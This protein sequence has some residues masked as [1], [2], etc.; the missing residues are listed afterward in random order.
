MSGEFD[1]DD[2]SPKGLRKQLE[3]QIAENNALKSELKTV[4]VK[5]LIG[6]KGWKF[7][8]AD[9]LSDVD[10]DKLEEQGD[11]IEAK[12]AARFERYVGQSSSQESQETGGSDGSIDET[13]DDGDSLWGSAFGASQ[14]LRS[15]GDRNGSAGEAR[16]D[17]LQDPFAAIASGVKVS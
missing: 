6:E 2:E 4:K 15:V 16:P 8:E 11:A 10:V 13:T 9:D 3:A 7:V 17:P 1:V 12:M 14:A 5:D